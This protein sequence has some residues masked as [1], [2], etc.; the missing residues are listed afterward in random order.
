MIK[1][2]LLIGVFF[3]MV[4]SWQEIS[5]Y[6]HT[7][8]EKTDAFMTYLNE[9]S[10]KIKSVFEDSAEVVNELTPNEPTTGELTPAES[11]EAD[12]Q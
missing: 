6:L 5:P 8:V 12:S 11:E 7:G 10:T 2:L 4:V 9:F 1:L 3:Y